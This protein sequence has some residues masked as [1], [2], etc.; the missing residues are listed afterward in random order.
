[1]ALENLGPF[2]ERFQNDRREHGRQETAKCAKVAKI[3]KVIWR[4]FS[5]FACF[6]SFRGSKK[7]YRSFLNPD[8]MAQSAAPPLALE[9][10]RPLRYVNALG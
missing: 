7:R 4:L 1:L 9:P 6:V 8:L 2:Q 10:R 3:P 5:L